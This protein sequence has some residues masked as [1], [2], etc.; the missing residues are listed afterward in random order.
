MKNLELVEKKNR[1]FLVPLHTLQSRF[2]YAFTSSY[3]QIDAD[4]KLLQSKV[5]LMLTNLIK[6]M[7]RPRLIKNRHFF[8]ECSLI[9]SCMK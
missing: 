4:D 7:P 1:F 6:F 2:V 9:A 5:V 8:G 3:Y